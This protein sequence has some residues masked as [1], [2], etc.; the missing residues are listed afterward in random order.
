M[1][2]SEINLDKLN[3]EQKEA[4]TFGDGPLLIVA[5]AGTGKTTVITQRI[6]WLIREKG[7]MPD[8]ILALTFTDK[9]AG[10]ME[11][12]VDKILPLGYTDLWISTFHSFCERILKEHG[13]EIG[14]STEFK[15]LNQTQDWLLIRQNLDKF[16]LDYY[17]PLGNP[18]KFIHALIKHFS[19]CKDEL[20]SPDDYLKYAEKLKLDSDSAEFV[21]SDDPEAMASEIRR[22]EELSNAY[23]VYQ[24]LLL[25]NN[26]LDFGDLINYCLELFKKRKHILQKYRQQFKYILVDE[27]QDT[28]YA[29]YELIKLLATP[30]NNITVVGDDD[31]SIYKF[32]GA[33]ISNILEFK[34]DFPNSAEI[35]LNTN[36]RSKQNILDLAYQFIQLNNP[37]RL[38]VRLG[39]R[40]LEL[41]NQNLEQ[42]N[43]KP[44]FTKELK[45]A[46]T[47]KGLIE[48]LPEA[49]ADEEVAAVVNKIQELCQKKDCRFSDFAILVRANEQANAFIAGL[50]VAGLPYQFVASK[51]LYTKS[52][53]MDVVAFLKMLDN[54]HESPAFYRLLSSPIVNIDPKDLIKLTHLSH[55]KAWSLYETAR[56]VKAYIKISEKSQLLISGLISLI[57]K[58]ATMI[59]EKTVS[60][61]VL[62][63]LETGRYIEWINNQEEGQKRE[64]FNYLG[65]FYKKIKDFEKTNDDRSVKAYLNNLELELESGEQGSLQSLLEEEGPDTVRIMTVH[66]AKGLEFK[67]VFLVNLVDRRFPTIER[68][69]PIELPD[70]LV[71]EIIPEGNIHLEEERRLFYVGITRAK[72]GIF[73]TS[74]EDYGGAR[75]K[76]PSR[77]LGEIGFGERKTK[78]KK[79]QSPVLEKIKKVKTSDQGRVTSENIPA[80]FSFTQL[81]AFETCPLQ[82]KY[83]HILKIPVKGK[84]T[85]SF[86]KTTHTT[87]QKFYQ[88][89]IERSG[90]RQADLF[91]AQPTKSED[92]AKKT[93]DKVKFNELIDIYEQSWIEDWYESKK[94]KEG[95]YKKG[96]AILKEYY[97]K[98]PDEVIPPKYLEKGFTVKIGE[99]SVRGVIDRVDGLGDGSIEIIDYKTGKPKSENKLDIDSKEQLLI[100]QIA[101]AE[102]FKEKVAKLTFYYLDNNSK[103]SFLGE[104]KD[105]EKIKTKIISEIEEII[106]MD[107]QD[108]SRLATP[109]QHKCLWCDFKDICGYKII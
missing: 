92:A 32:R 4:V 58:H 93:K 1:I 15:L 22:L 79:E 52:V 74:A 21:K 68:G 11:E 88:L 29:Q 85:F 5:G 27:F 104:E 51:G 106:K 12:R 59:K 64:T 86:G 53:V 34:K 66:S 41:E 10:E 83:S 48:H 33:S 49:T 82:Y 56:Q 43:S 20:V 87:L 36:Y 105:L 73:F 107:F 30:K 19:R 62:S 94:Q 38:E 40:S 80:K 109:S 97:D 70:E 102:I 101:A 98:L 17:R 103:V 99:Y 57:D 16:E 81:K 65:Q 31:Q 44:V 37:N 8:Q 67:Y 25:D 84:Y 75:K 71:K 26:A 91:S 61:I 55:K 6:A 42:N 78:I 96:K 9:A 100:Y 90:S 7:L 50:E 3:N 72:E 63:F 18:T 24:R 54:Y 60:Q 46:L 89:F 108:D 2:K 47:G 69:E 77:F 39:A 14:L 13:L 45:S 76:K 35:F 23:H 95:Y 28:N